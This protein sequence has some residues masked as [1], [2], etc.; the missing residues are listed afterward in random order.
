M[1][2]QKRI[3]DQGEKLA[4]RY[5]LRHGYAIRAVNWSSLFGE[6]DIIAEKA[7]LLVFIEVKAR[8]GRDTQSALAAISPAKQERMLKAIYQYLDEA[9]ISWDA[10]WR[11]DAIAVA[12][13]G[14]NAARIAHVEDA[15]DW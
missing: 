5:L 12:L 9:G 6:L 1:S 3:G 8:R 15:F 2:Q 7:G 4:R 14:Q 11:I 13:D 10:P